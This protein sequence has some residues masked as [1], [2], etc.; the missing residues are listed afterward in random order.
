MSQ[1]LFPSAPPSP[2]HRLKLLLT[3]TDTLGLYVQ[4]PRRSG[5]IILIVDKKK[6]FLLPFFLSFFPTSYT[7]QLTPHNLDYCSTG[8]GYA[9]A[10][11]RPNQSKD[12]RDSM[13][14]LFS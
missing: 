1:T 12:R 7:S 4:V 8:G 3:N 13:I 11:M 14:S 10:Y 5:R 6:A 9:Y 2:H